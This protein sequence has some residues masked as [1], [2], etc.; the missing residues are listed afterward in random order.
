MTLHEEHEQIDR[1]IWQA[2]L[3]LLPDHWSSAALSVSTESRI[4]SGLAHSIEN[5]DGENDI[6]I[7]SDEIFVL[8]AEHYDSFRRHGSPWREVIWSVRYDFDDEKWKCLTDIK[9]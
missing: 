8:T 2:I 1:A 4:D 9:Y 5:L 6:C 7:P 3:A